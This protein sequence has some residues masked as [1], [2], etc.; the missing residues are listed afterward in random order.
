MPLPDGQT[1]AFISELNPLQ[2]VILAILQVPTCWYDYRF[3]FD[4][5]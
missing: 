3:L 4:S 2:R 1:Y 5:S